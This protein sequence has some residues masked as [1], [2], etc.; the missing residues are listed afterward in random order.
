MSFSHMYIEQMIRCCCVIVGHFNTF[1]VVYLYFLPLFDSFS[2]EEDRK[3]YN[4]QQ[5]SV[6]FTV[7]QHEHHLICIL[8]VEMCV[9]L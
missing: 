9:C 4:M 8:P 7:L 6:F 1:V 5:S 2:K 3:Q